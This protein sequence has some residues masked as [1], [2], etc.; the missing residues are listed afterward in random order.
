MW[1]F[2]RCEFRK[3]KFMSGFVFATPGKDQKCN[4]WCELTSMQVASC[5]LANMRNIPASD[6]YHLYCKLLISLHVDSG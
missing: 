5:L 6:K 3:R 2:S 4:N 1:I